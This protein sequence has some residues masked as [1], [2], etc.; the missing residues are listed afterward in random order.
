MAITSLCI[1]DFRNLAFAELT[2][3]T[4]GLNVISGDNGSGKTSLLEAIHYLGLGRSFRTATSARLIRQETEKFSLFAQLVRENLSNLP[5]G[6]ERTLK[7]AHELGILLREVVH[8]KPARVDVLTADD[9]VEIDEDLRVAGTDGDRHRGLGH[10][11]AVDAPGLERLAHR[12]KVDLEELHLRDVAPALRQPGFEVHLGTGMQPV[13][14]D[15][16]P[17]EIFGRLQ[18][19]V[20][21]DAERHR[22]YAGH[23]YR[24][25]ADDNDESDNTCTQ[26]AQNPHDVVLRETLGA[27]S[28]TATDARSVRSSIERGLYRIDHFQKVVTI[29][30]ATKC[31]LLAHRRHR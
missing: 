24:A 22:R 19:R 30:V 13:Y 8:R 3:F 1:T 28:S 16:L 4:R 29:P 10:H 31:A 25:R 21:G 7:A 9:F 17:F 6:V 20:G 5:V 15:R 27:F 18:R 2:P 26:V 23:A 12:G 11:C 14:R